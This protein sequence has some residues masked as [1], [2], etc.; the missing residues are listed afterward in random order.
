MTSRGQPNENYYVAQKAV[1][2]LGTNS[3]D[4]AARLC[5][6]PSTAALKG[7]I[8]VAATTCSYTDLIGTDL[9]VFIG[10]NVA[11]NQPVMMKYLY[12]AR[13]CGTKVA[14]VNP[15]REPAMERYWVPSNVESAVFGTK[16]TDRFFQV[17]MGGDI[18]FL[19]GRSS[20]SSNGTGWTRAFI[21]GFTTGFDEMA[22]CSRRPELG[23]P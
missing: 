22:G 20:T 5:H 7:A 17:S 21:D 19:N 12:H 6:A 3:I 15:Y 13:K 10:S 23:S 11:Q 16:M 1:R 14:V 18:A 4:S 9:I 8:G 2:A